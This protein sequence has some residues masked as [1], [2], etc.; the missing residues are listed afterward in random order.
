MRHKHKSS[1]MKLAISRMRSILRSK[2]FN[3]VKKQRNI[4]ECPGFLMSFLASQ[5]HE[6]SCYVGYHV[7]DLCFWPFSP[8]KSIGWLVAW[9]ID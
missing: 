7:S 6:N 5:P 3:G 4:E 2:R 9:L 8:N 1:E